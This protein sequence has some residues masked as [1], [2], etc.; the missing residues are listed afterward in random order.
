VFYE[1]QLTSVVIGNGVD[2]IGD[3]AF[4]KN[5]LT[6]ITIGAGVNLEDDWQSEAFDRNFVYLY[7][8]N[9]KRAGTYIRPNSN[10]SN[11]TRQP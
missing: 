6:S 4:G 5:T 9:N 8:R 7:L 2:F 3:Y 1:N 10:S 11:W